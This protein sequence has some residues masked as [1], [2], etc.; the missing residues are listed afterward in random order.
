MPRPR[1]VWLD[2]PEDGGVAGP[3]EPALDRSLAGIPSTTKFVCHSGAEGALVL[4]AGGVDTSSC[5]AVFPRL[6]QIPAANK[7]LVLTS[8]DDHGTPALSSQ[9]GVCAGA[10]GNFKVDAYDWGFCW[11]SWDALRSCAY[12]GQECEYALGNT[13]QNRF[14]GTWSDGTPIVGLKVQT[15]GLTAPQPTPARAPAPPKRNLID[16]PAT[17]KVTA[18]VRRSGRVTA[19]RGTAADDRGVASVELAVVRRK[20]STCSQLTPAGAFA[21]LKVCSRPSVLLTAKGTRAWTV[22]LPKHLEPGGYTLVVRATD[23][24]GQQRQSSPRAVDSR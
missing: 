8:P 3:G 2:D 19:V 22:T 13:P 23:S 17:A 21:A 4:N 1:A 9:H 7:S 12:T 10:L 14:I 11:R 6:G 5:N 15:S 18:V 20:G 24:A 16:R